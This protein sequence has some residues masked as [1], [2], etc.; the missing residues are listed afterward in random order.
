M[1]LLFRD[2]YDLLSG[3]RQSA[4]AVGVDMLRVSGCGMQAVLNEEQRRLA[5]NYMTLYNSDVTIHC[6]FKETLSNI[7]VCLKRLE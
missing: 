4:E 3:A 5:E 7:K 6:N 1:S 2:V